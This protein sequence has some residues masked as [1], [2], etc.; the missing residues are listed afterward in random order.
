MPRD[1]NGKPVATEE[2]LLEFVNKGRAA[3]G[4]NILEALLPSTPSDRNNCLIANALN[5]NCEVD[6]IKYHDD[7]GE[8]TW[9]M[10][11]PPNIGEDRAKS[12]AEALECELS[13]VRS[14]YEVGLGYTDTPC[15]FDYPNAEVRIILPRHI[16]NAA[17][18]FDAEEAFQEYVN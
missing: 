3:G 1:I 13:V 2:E 14:V 18:A 7:I 17:A 11:L 5:F 12:I 10:I 15:E 8:T 16:G 6:V 9:A 4:A